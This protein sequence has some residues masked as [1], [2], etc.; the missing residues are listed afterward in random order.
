MFEPH[1]TADGRAV[2]GNGLFNGLSEWDVDPDLWEEQAWLEAGRNLTEAEWDEYLG[3]DE[4]Y[5]ATCER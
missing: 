1:F 4:P 5:R 2:I 3:P